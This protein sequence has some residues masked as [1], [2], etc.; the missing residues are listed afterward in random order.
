MNF[1]LAFSKQNR[2]RGTQIFSLK[3]KFS[4]S[5]HTACVSSK[6]PCVIRKCGRKEFRNMFFSRLNWM[7]KAKFDSFFLHFAFHL[8]KAMPFNLFHVTDWKRCA[9]LYLALGVAG[10]L[11]FALH[12]EICFVHIHTL[13]AAND[14]RVNTFNCHC[15]DKIRANS[16]DFLGDNI[17]SFPQWFSASSIAHPYSHPQPPSPTIVSFIYIYSLNFRVIIT[18]SNLMC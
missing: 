13:C 17:I 11:T 10:W 5:N 15:H 2:I 18:Q 16:K 6:T 8:I 12:K 4:E 14:S 3:N 9:C 7:K 1:S